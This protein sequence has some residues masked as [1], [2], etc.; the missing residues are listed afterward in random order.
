[1]RRDGAA[2]VVVEPQAGFSIAET[3]SKVVVGAMEVV[4]H[5]TYGF[6]RIPN[7][8]AGVN[9]YLEWIE[10]HIV[11]RVADCHKYDSITNPTHSIHFTGS[12]TPGTGFTGTRRT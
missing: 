12:F 11:P 5:L 7:A 2:A 10:L 6:E 1:M 9:F 4:L 3:I 8:D